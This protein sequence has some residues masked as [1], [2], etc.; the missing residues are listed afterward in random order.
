M[1][2]QLWRRTNWT[3]RLGLAC[4]LL[5]VAAC[6]AGLRPVIDRGDAPEGVGGTISGVVRAATSNSPVSGRKVTAVEVTSGATHEASTAINGGYTMK[7]PVGVY[8]LEVELHDRE[9]LVEKPPNLTIG[10]SDLDA[11]RDFVIAM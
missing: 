7:V 10:R 8:R 9:R 3:I 1:T 2:T 11:Q 4:F 6:G 5:T